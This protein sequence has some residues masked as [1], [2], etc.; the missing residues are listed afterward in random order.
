M[1]SL[2]PAVPTSEP[3]VRAANADQAQTLPTMHSSSGGHADRE[4]SHQKVEK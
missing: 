4:L 2:L 3:R 1:G